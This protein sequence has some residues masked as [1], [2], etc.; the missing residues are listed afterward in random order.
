MPEN[1]TIIESWN[2]SIFEQMTSLHGRLNRLRYFWM[3]IILL[4]GSV[5]YGALVGA[6]LAILIGILGLPWYLFD[7]GLGV[8]TIP[9]LYPAYAITVKRLQDMNWGKGWTTYL[10]VFII[11]QL[12]WGLTPLGSI[13]SDVLSVIMVAV[14]IPLISAYFA[15]GD[16]GP[17]EF[18]PDP[19]VG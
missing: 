4:I 16:R 2:M 7:L 13:A 8:L 6:F 17:N 3:S 9:L 5:I 19:L 10:Q 1:F 14:Y 18:G 15:P 12:I 11:I